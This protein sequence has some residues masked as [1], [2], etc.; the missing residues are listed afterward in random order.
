[1]SQPFDA[2]DFFDESEMTPEQ[3]LSAMGQTMRVMQDLRR[4]NEILVGRRAFI[5]ERTSGITVHLV[6]AKS[7][8]KKM[9]GLDPQEDGSVNVVELFGG[10]G[11]R[12]PGVPVVVNGL[13][14]VKATP[15]R[16]DNPLKNGCSSET[17]SENI[18]ESM[19]AGKPQK[20][21]VAIALSHHRQQGC[22]YPPTRKGNPAGRDP[23]DARDQEQEVD[24]RTEGSA[25][26]CPARG[27]DPHM[28]GWFG[29]PKN[30]C[31]TC[32]ETRPR[33]KKG[34]R[35]A[36]R[37]GNPVDQ[38]QEV[39]AFFHA[40]RSG[41]LRGYRV[42]L[43]VPEW[44][45]DVAESAGVR[46]AWEDRIKLYASTDDLGISDK[47]VERRMVDF[48]RAADAKHR[49][50]WA[51]LEIRLSP[52][53]S[54]YEVME[55]G[56]DA[57][58]V[59]HTLR[60][61]T[62][63]SRDEAAASSRARI[64]RAVA[65]GEADGGKIRVVDR[66]SV[67]STVFLWPSA[68][69][70]TQVARYRMGLAKLMMTLNRLSPAVA[71]SPQGLAL[72]LSLPVRPGDQASPFDDDPGLVRRALA[73]LEHDGRVEHVARGLWR[74]RET[75]AKRHQ[76]P[77]TLHPNREQWEG[78]SRGVRLSSLPQHELAV[79]TEHE[80]EHSRSR[81]VA[82]RTAADHLVEDPAYYTHLA[83][84][85]GHRPNPVDEIEPSKDMRSIQRALSRIGWEISYVDANAVSGV[86][87]VQVRRGDLIV[88][89]HGESNRGVVMVERRSASRVP[90]GR[91]GDR[92]M[93]ERIETELVAPPIR[94]QG[95]RVG[96]RVLCNIIA[97][98]AQIPTG[99][100][101]GTIGAP[102]LA[103][104]EAGDGR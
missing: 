10:S 91:R 84:M 31:Y 2:S 82:R 16:H 54:E 36:P 24:E 60:R 18:R 1:M 34:A 95:F 89:L 63:T 11:D 57:A 83:A 6:A 28:W 49:A 32:G 86:L 87:R 42:P 56:I 71:S 55:I 75:P 52:H 78:L 4:G 81:L 29:R 98:N 99:E 62:V 7:K 66:R 25:E 23:R 103:L 88:T 59:P 48:I 92:F 17:I 8:G 22:A 40:W 76:N 33:A 61:H 90:V 3:P 68:F 94:V 67:A 37:K 9:Y 85:E 70:K 100:V 20:Q 14:G 104:M 38:A 41:G 102:I 96:M 13:L 50:K 79:G 72:R 97:E 46:A 27:D 26:A 44:M 53:G 35:T 69:A 65:G 39:T 73:E 30:E 74:W 21:A 5:V 51:H 19:H 93:A 12:K 64:E 80:L 45:D 77:I 47:E 101:R 58:G 15:M 43:E